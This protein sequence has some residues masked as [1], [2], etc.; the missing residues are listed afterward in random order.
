MFDPRIVLSQELIKIGITYSDA[1][2]IALDAGSSQVVVN[3]IYLKEYNYSRAIRTQALSLIGK[4]Y[5]G[6]LFENLEE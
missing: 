5:S 4:F 6:E 2:T 3:N 1:M